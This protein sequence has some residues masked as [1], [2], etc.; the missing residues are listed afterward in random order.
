MI[1]LSDIKKP[2]P[3]KISVGTSRSSIKEYVENVYN[4]V[5]DFGVFLPSIGKNLQRPLVW[6][7]KQ[8]QELVLSVFKDVYIPPICM[9]QHKSKPGVDSCKLEVIDG[10]QRPYTMLD[11][12]K[13][14]F[15]IVV[16]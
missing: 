9:I 10:K 14:I 6:N 7:L 16:K 15:P 5:L 13:N 8:K 11:F 3:F 4:D 1:T 12:Y 2:L